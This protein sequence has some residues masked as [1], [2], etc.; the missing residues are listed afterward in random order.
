MTTYLERHYDSDAPERQEQF[1]NLLQMPDP[2]LYNLLLGRGEL[3]DPDLAG[4]LQVLR[5]L[6]G[7]K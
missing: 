6:T 5:K 1:R 3:N 7:Q 2:D 4:L